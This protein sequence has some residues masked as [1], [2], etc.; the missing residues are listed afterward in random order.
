MAIDLD[1]N[2]FT[3]LN[4]NIID[5]NNKT[6]PLANMVLNP[7]PV[8]STNKLAVKRGTTW[9]IEGEEA[10]NGR[11]QNFGDISGT[12][13]LDMD[14]AG[15]RTA[16][17]AEVVGDTFITGF[18][19][20]FSSG[21]VYVLFLRQDPIG[22]H[23]VRWP[24][25]ASILGMTGT[26]AD[27][28]TE[29]Y[30][31]KLP[32]GKV[33]IKCKAFQNTVEIGSIIK[34]FEYPASTYP[35]DGGNAPISFTW[36]K[37]PEI[38]HGGTLAGLYSDWE[39]ASDE[40]FT[41]LMFSSYGNTVDL[42]SIEVVLSQSG[43]AYMRTRYGGEIGGTPVVSPWEQMAVQVSGVPPLW[44]P[45]EITTA[46]WLDAAD[47]ATITLNGSA[48]SQWS[49]KS[50]NARHVLQVAAEKQPTRIATG[51]QFDGSNDV[52]ACASWAVP[53]IASVFIVASNQR[54]TLSTSFT[55]CLM[56]NSPFPAAPN[57]KGFALHTSNG[58]GSTSQRQLYHE[59]V[60]GTY[61]LYKN[62]VISDTQST[63]YL[64]YQEIFITTEHHNISDSL[65]GRVANVG[66]LLLSPSTYY[67]GKNNIHEIVVLDAAEDLTKTQLIEG[68]LAHKWDGL[69]AVT[70]LVDAL[71][72]DH[73][74]KINPPM[75]PA[76]PR[77]PYWENVTLCINASGFAD[78]TTI[79]DETGKIPSIVNGDTK[80]RTVLGYNSIYLD[81]SGDY[82]RFDAD[83]TD[84]DFGSDSF[85]IEAWL[86]LNAIAGNLFTQRTAGNTSGISFGFHNNQVSMALGNGSGW[87]Y[88]PSNFNLGVGANTLFHIALIRDGNTIRVC[89]DGTQIHSGTTT[90]VVG[91]VGLPVNIGWDPGN[92]GMGYYPLSGHIKGFRITKG[93]PRYTGT[94]FTPDAAPFLT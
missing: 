27:Q 50:G 26:D 90:G 39:V 94:S 15:C 73:P 9:N 91:P 88:A 8:G 44:T 55:D 93:D 42:Y 28:L 40:L 67:Y 7:V 82:V 46:L 45:A 32:N 10:Y 4:N 43:L 75:I 35:E 62:G 21:V 2:S 71:P 12:I 89:R 63:K 6:A 69:L 33:F 53:N 23:S 25:G 77:D 30:I 61:K 36:S 13:S 54:T 22:G 86:Y 78:S 80:I 31:V 5:I 87:F 24:Y 52:L 64:S 38:A 79:V 68:Y 18:G 57:N 41:V 72:S 48:V 66:L 56:S 74:Y 51:L 20:N 3:E 29:V 92:S 19:D 83:G 70:T 11:L 76:P 17:I 60:T 81:G 1:V 65:I 84:F 34:E 85:C 59:A 14:G 58:W 49:D 16:M 47:T 37:N